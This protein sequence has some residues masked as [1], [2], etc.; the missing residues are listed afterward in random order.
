MVGALGP[1]QSRGTWGTAGSCT[2]PLCGAVC[3]GAPVRRVARG[4]GAPGCRWHRAAN[5]LGQSEKADWAG[6]KQ[7][8]ASLAEQHF[9]KDT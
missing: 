5:P 2:S 1:G 6:S 3:R 4:A 7:L 8:P 9:S